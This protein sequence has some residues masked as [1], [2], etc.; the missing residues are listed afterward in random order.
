MQLNENIKTDLQKFYDDNNNITTKLINLMLQNDLYFD[1]D[2][3]LEFEKKAKE[4][5]LLNIKRNLPE[6]DNNNSILFKKEMNLCKKKLNDLNHTCSIIN[7]INEISN[8]KPTV[9]YQQHKLKNKNEGNCSLNSIELRNKSNKLDNCININYNNNSN[10]TQLN[11]TSKV[12]EN[13]N[14]K[15]SFSKYHKNFN[16]EIKFIDNNKIVYINSY[17][18]NQKKIKKHNRC[19]EKK[20]SSKYRGVSKNGNKWQVIIHNKNCKSY[21][22]TYSSEEDAARIYDI[23]SLKYRGIKAKT[24]FEYNNSQIKKIIE[25]TIDIKSKNVNEILS[26]LNK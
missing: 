15:N 1:N 26:F 2:F 8:R 16:N 12:I 14:I 3:S 20:R 23:I 10:D 19:S 17:L 9:K 7:I 24:N 6:N 22:N 13:N 18:L 5:S 25:T 11:K 4:I 21:I